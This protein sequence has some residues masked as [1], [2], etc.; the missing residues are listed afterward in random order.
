MKTKTKE[1]DH[2][3][4]QPC[5][6]LKPISTS[7]SKG[8]QSK[9]DKK[10]ALV[11]L[12]LAMLEDDSG[13]ISNVRSVMQEKSTPEQTSQPLK[14]IRP[15]NTKGCNKKGHFA[16]NGP[17]VKIILEQ[18]DVHPS[19]YEHM[20]SVQHSKEQ[21]SDSNSSAMERAVEVQ[22][23]LPIKYPS[24]VK[25]MLHSHIA[26]G[27]WLGLQKKFCVEH[28]PQSDTMM[29]L[30]DESGKISHAKYLAAKVGLSAGWRGFSIA[31]NL[32]EGDVVV[33]QLI[34]KTTFKVY[35][36]RKDGLG[37]TDCGLGLLD[38][39]TDANLMTSNDNV[40]DDGKREG[41]EK[42]ISGSPK[43]DESRDSEVLDWIRLS[44]PGESVNLESFDKFSILVNGVRIDAKFPDHIRRKYYNLCISQNSCLHEKLIKDLNCTLVI[45]II[46][47]TVNIS[48]AI[49]DCDCSARVPESDLLIYDRT[50]QS[51][52]LMGMSIHSIRL[53]IHRL[54]R[55]VIEKEET[56]AMEAKVEREIVAE[57]MKDID[58]K[59]KE[60]RK[61]MEG[62]DE[63]IEI[64]QENTKMKRLK[65]QKM[66]NF[67][68][69]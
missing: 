13:A 59:L 34:K 28:L 20:N 16:E 53:Q 36:I 8:N 61:Q 39:D 49:R 43:S 69:D 67:S 15:T 14:I 25:N 48:D 62:M 7:I 60:L 2:A 37:E 47:E 35:I 51:F 33:F 45:G 4:T 42:I 29:E 21:S 58:V 26:P 41:Q 54:L 68:C 5:S 11:A 56:I 55:H 44:E 31:H 6:K 23:S 1:Y 32:E 3:L 50:L 63:E 19:Y 18:N 40:D 30:I 65:L 27:F 66:E 22:A 24:F 9:A 17:N 64:M 57:R 10:R 12:R 38:L 46:N 52:E